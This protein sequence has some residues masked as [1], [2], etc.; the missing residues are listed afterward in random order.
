VTTP[1]A[2]KTDP[3]PQV[4]GTGSPLALMGK[5]DQARTWNRAGYRGNRPGDG[6][7]SPL[8]PWLRRPIGRTIAPSRPCRF[9]EGNHFDLACR[10]RSAHTR[11]PRAYFV[12]ENPDYAVYNIE[13]T[14]DT[15]YDMDHQEFVNS[16]FSAGNSYGDY[17]RYANEYGGG[18]INDELQ[19]GHLTARPSVT[20]TAVTASPTLA[21]QPVPTAK[22]PGRSRNDRIPAHRTAECEQCGEQFPSRTRLFNHLKATN[23]FTQYVHH[24][25]TPAEQVTGVF[26]DPIIIA[27]QADAVTGT[28]YE[29]RKYNYVEV[30]VRLAA[31]SEATWACLDT[32]CGMSLINV[33]WITDRLPQLC[34]VNRASAVRVK[35]IGSQSHVSNSFIVLTMYLPNADGSKLA[36]ITRELHL[37]EGLGCKILIGVDIIKPERITPNVHG[38]TAHIGSCDLDV[39]IRVMARG[40]QIVCRKVVAKERKLVMPGS[41]TLVPITMK[42]LPNNRDFEFTPVYDDR[43]KYLAQSGGFLRALVNADTTAMVFHNTSL[44]PVVIHKHLKIGYV[45]D[46]TPESYHGHVDVRSDEARQL[47]EDATMEGVWAGDNNFDDTHDV[48][49][50]GGLAPAFHGKA[51]LEMG[52]PTTK[53]SVTGKFGAENVDVNATDDITANQTRT[54]RALCE[55]F[56]PIFED[57]GLVADEP[58]EN[59]MRITLKPG[60]QLQ[61]KGPYAASQRDRK[62]IDSTF[63]KMHNEDK[64]EWSPPWPKPGT[65]PAA[66]PAFVVWNGDKGRVVTDIRDVNDKTLTDPFPMP[67]QQE[68]LGG[69][70]AKRWLSV[71]D[72][73]AAFLQR[74]VAVEDRWKLT[75][76][77]HR[78]LERYKVAPMGYKN[79]PAH[80]QR[81]MDTLLRPVA[82]TTR[83]YIDDIVV[84]TET[85]EEHL[86]ELRKLFEILSKAML[87]VTAAKCH[88]GYHS[89]TLLGRKVDR[90]G[91]ST[92]EE[93]VA[94]IQKWEF[95]RTLK[96]LETFI[97]ICN[98]QRDHIPYYARIVQGLERLK[99][100]L[101]KHAPKQG[102]ARRA[103]SNKC[104]ITEREVENLREARASFEALKQM[105]AGPNALIHF[106]PASPLIIRLDASKQRGFGTSIMQVPEE[107]MVENQVS[108]EDIVDGKYDSHLERPVCYLSKRLNK[109]EVNYW[110]TEL[111]VA[112]LVW[113]VQKA[114]AMVDDADKVV[115]YTD[116][117]AT[118]G[119]AAQ[120]NFKSST[121]HKQN[122]RLV[123]TSLYLSQFDMTLRHVPGK[124]NVIPD[125]LSRLLAIDTAEEI[126]AVADEPDLYEELFH[127]EPL[128]SV[129]H[130]SD[131]LVDKLQKAYMDDPYVRPKLSE[132]RRRF[133]HAKSLPVDYINFRLV[134]ATSAK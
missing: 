129:I 57:R 121:P 83:C 25:E 31:D 39:P 41:R 59:W 76:V 34:I 101:L 93:R 5:D 111:E 16:F 131:E 77:T 95:P 53:A 48:D 127:M 21:K 100:N 88:V 29:F 120:T 9:C 45:E 13:E 134:D 67:Q 89:V 110:P 74:R 128:T 65:M 113:S 56:G 115:V 38:E 46:W 33:D 97:G 7:L 73:T 26:V 112:A 92:R 118:I 132:L 81:Y 19:C 86:V 47:L 4:A 55:E 109:H 84:A 28:G 32:G 126:E 85:Y 1:N 123:R 133:A 30:G 71:F 104:A 3:T 119:I 20:R 44:E 68:I 98:Y 6:N 10:Q 79:S 58:E 35:G 22:N 108:A 60:V 69:L 94:A 91:L 63:D 24:V 36:K 116:H 125:A 52:V 43:T 80:M 103:Y 99:T 11:A 62:C 78:G 130:V 50:T 27:S 12:E 42:P 18:P 102:P 17:E 23:H 114:R 70:R 54:L 61:S 49:D 117:N 51:T 2:P 37:V 124:Q 75:V 90:F 72:L 14:G 87:S 40:R 107:I 105:L 8:P 82:S 106:N 96:D 122:L 15:A 64:I 66:S